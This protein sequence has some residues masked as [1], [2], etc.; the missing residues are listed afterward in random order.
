MGFALLVI[1]D[2]AVG[3]RKELLAGGDEDDESVTAIGG[4]KRGAGGEVRVVAGEHF[5][6]GAVTLDS[7]FHG[8]VGQK[9]DLSAVVKAGAGRG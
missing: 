9:T 2:G 5:K 8:E 4:E 6:A 1:V 3:K 7:D